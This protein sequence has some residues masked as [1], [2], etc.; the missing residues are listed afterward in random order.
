MILAVIILC[1]IVTAGN[2]LGKSREMGARARWQDQASC[3]QQGFMDRQKK[4]G[5]LQTQTDRKLHTLGDECPGSRLRKV[6]I[7]ENLL[8][9]NINFC[10]L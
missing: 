1:P 5:N 10:S 7:G 8:H 2:L 9:P 6:E 4:V 3:K